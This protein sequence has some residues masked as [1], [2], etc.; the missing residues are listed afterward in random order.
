MI[1]YVIEE[2][3]GVFHL[4]SIVP[5]DFAG[6]AKNWICSGTEVFCELQRNRLEN[7]K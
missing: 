4:Y 5:T 7:S 1:K 2:Q 3:E 6:D